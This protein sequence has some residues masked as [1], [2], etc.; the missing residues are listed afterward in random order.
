MTRR[1]RRGVSW[2]AAGIVILAV[3]ML[4]AT[5]GL[6]VPGGMRLPVWAW[7][8]SL[9]VGVSLV[10]L[11]FG[12]IVDEAARLNREEVE[13]DRASQNLDELDDAGAD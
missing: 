8:T 4:L 5:G 3:L 7:V 2:T 12:G 13:A 10:G 11:G 9:S 1:M 6:A